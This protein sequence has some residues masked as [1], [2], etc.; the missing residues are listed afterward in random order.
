MLELHEKIQSH[1]YP[2]RW[3]HQAAEGWRQLPETLAD[4]V[5]G[6]TVM[7]DT[8]RKALF[9]AEQLERAVEAMEDCESGVQRL[10]G[11]V[12]GGGG[13]AAAV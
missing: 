1:P 10:R 5:Y 3:L 4:S 7:E 9:W 11:P 12:S 8:V 6:R 2:V 13:T